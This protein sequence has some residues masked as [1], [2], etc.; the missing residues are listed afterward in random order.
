MRI[1]ISY[2]NADEPQARILAQALEAVGHSVW[3]DHTLAAGSVFSEEIRREIE[4]A[5]RVLVLWTR[6]SVRSNWVIDEANLAKS[7][8]KLTPLR[9][10]DCELPF[11]FGSLHTIDV[12]GADDLRSI[13]ERLEKGLVRK[14]RKRR[15]PVRNVLLSLVGVLVVAGGATGGALFWKDR[16]A[17]SQ[18]EAFTAQ[19]HH[20]DDKLPEASAEFVDECPES[21]VASA[22][23]RYEIGNW[24]FVCETFYDGGIMALTLW[25]GKGTKVVS[26]PPSSNGFWQLTN[27]KGSFTVYSG[28]NELLP[29]PFSGAAFAEPVHTRNLPVA[30][31]I[32][33]GSALRFSE[34]GTQDAFIYEGFGEEESG[35][36][37]L[38]FAVTEDFIVLRLSSG[39]SLMLNRLGAEIAFRDQVGRTRFF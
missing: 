23:R 38:E 11:G 29:N 15:R 37:S 4:K 28:T 1:F 33:P 21:G 10:D 16:A 30:G 9:L 39:D 19:V 13:G 6:Q 8:G 5:E 27:A 2:A 32:D 31:Q 17:R 7:Q 25:T 18:M 35:D 22:N 26:L 34:T 24:S 3:W 36:A 12:R 14:P 20:F